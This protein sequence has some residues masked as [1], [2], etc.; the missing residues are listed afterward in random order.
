MPKPRRT[1]PRR[2]ARPSRAATPRPRGRTL[3]GRVRS[4]TDATFA[5]LTAE[6]PAVL[7]DLWAPWCPPCLALA[8]IIKKV[9]ARLGRKV[10]VLRV[11]VDD[12][13]ELTRRFRVTVIPKLV[14]IRGG[15]RTSRVGLLGEAALLDWVRAGAGR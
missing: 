15:R 1:P 11:N 2:T 9:A 3:V 7:V 6:R 4:A 13:P 14:L 5:R 8:P 10:T 12:N